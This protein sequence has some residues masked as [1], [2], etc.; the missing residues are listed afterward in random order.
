MK[1]INESMLDYLD[2][3]LTSQGKGDNWTSIDWVQYEVN[4]TSISQNPM[5]NGGVISKDILG[6]KTKTQ[7]FTYSLVFKYS[8]DVYEMLA[9]GE[10]LEDL[11]YYV[12]SVE[13]PVLSKGRKATKLSVAQTPYLSQVEKG[14]EHGV[15]VVILELE[16]FEPKR[17]KGD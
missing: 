8:Q 12:E 11:T 3:F 15:Y 6:N 1:T 9:N 10:M 17:A 16:Y 4:E 5:M 7:A 14:N 2:Q 13:L